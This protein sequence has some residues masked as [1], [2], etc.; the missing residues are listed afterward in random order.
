MS[1]LGYLLKS[2]KTNCHLNLRIQRE[3]QF[4]AIVPLWKIRYRVEKPLDCQAN[5]FKRALRGRQPTKFNCFYFVCFNLFCRHLSK[6]DSKKEKR[7]KKKFFFWRPWPGAW[8]RPCLWWHDRANPS[9]HKNQK[10][11]PFFPHSNSTT[12][13][14]FKLLSLNLHN[15]NLQ[16]SKTPPNQTNSNPNH[17]QTSFQT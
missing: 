2:F 17:L 10:N 4:D 9:A 13:F 14:I 12:S 7:K 6:H 1:N 15:L 11:F 16:T 8:H 5:D 3:C